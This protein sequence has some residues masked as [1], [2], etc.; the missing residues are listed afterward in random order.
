[1]QAYD[2]PIYIADAA[3][4]LMAHKPELGIKDPYELNEDQYKAAL[5]LLRAAAQA[6]QRYWHDAMVQVDDFT[7]E[8]VVASGSWPFQ[9]NL[10]K[11]K[12]QPIASH[13]PRGRRHR[14]GRHHHDARRR[15]ASELRLHVAGALAR[16]RSCRATS[17][18]GSARCRRCRRPARATR[19]S[20]DEGC[21]TNGF[22]DFDKINFWRT[23]VAKCATQSAGCVPYYRWVIGL[24]RGHR[25]PVSEH[26]ASVAPVPRWR[27]RSDVRRR[28]M[29]TAVEF[30]RR[31]A[32]HFGAV[33]AVDGVDAS[34][35][36]TGEFF[37]MLGPSGS[38]KTT[39]LRLIAGF[40]QPTAGDIA[41]FGEPMPRACRPTAQRQHRVPGL[42][43]VPAS[44]RAR[45]RRLRA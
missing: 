37:A 33:R 31:H 35:S 11:A 34:T 19:C 30:Q 14:L 32:A 9:V 45:Q 3:L 5:D 25:R 4:Y 1:M 39:C 15:R 38:G 41:I 42:R 16:A 8:G 22:D 36:P 43:A 13:R 27:A 26:E 40:E 12:K 24:Y 28:R 21:A 18:P 10:L 44:E 17:P 7:N 29:T 20:T 2:G 6:R 23:P